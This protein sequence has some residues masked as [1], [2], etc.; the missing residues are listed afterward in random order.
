MSKY[1]VASLFVFPITGVLCWLVFGL[2]QGLGLFSILIL[3]GWATNLE[4]RGKR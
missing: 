4:N 3:F 1:E 2:W